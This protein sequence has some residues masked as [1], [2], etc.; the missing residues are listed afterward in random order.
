MSGHWQFV[1]LQ[2]YLFMIVSCPKSY[3]YINRKDKARMAYLNSCKLDKLME[4]YVSCTKLQL[5]SATDTQLTLI[6][7]VLGSL[8]NLTNENG[9]YCTLNDFYE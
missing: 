6:S 1:F 8:H 9:S 2:R 7:V 5:E 3:K 4:L